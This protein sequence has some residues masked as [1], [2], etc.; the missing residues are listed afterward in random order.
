M[1]VLRKTEQRGLDQVMGMYASEVEQVVKA[2][3]MSN[4]FVGW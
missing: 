1:N 2:E 4:R 3:R